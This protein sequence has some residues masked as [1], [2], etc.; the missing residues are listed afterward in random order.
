MVEKTKKIKQSRREIEKKVKSGKKK[1]KEQKRV[2]NNLIFE[3]KVIR[4]YTT[5]YY[6]YN[7]QIKG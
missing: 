3:K 7:G 5:N 4:V 2:K 1:E 6:N